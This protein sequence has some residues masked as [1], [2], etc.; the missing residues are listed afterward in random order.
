MGLCLSCLGF[1][2]KDDS[3]HQ[4]LLGSDQ[5]NY[6]SHGYYIPGQFPS[7][8]NHPNSHVPDRQAL[9]M[10][11]EYLDRIV[12]QTSENLIDIFAP[13][14]LPHTTTSTTPDSKKKWFEEVLAKMTPPEFTHEMPVVLDPSVVTQ[15]E[16]DWLE[17]L[18]KSGEEAVEAVGKITDVGPLVVGLEYYGPSA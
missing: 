12:A 4:G 17:S 8:Q 16:R 18:L 9:L 15:S 13:P 1:S 7:S 3:E 11:R 5:N 14:V 6:N 2:D 10:E